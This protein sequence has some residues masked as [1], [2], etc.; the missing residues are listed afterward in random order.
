MEQTRDQTTQLSAEWVGGAVARR[1][2]CAWRRRLC[3]TQEVAGVYRLDEGAVRD[4]FF[5]CLQ[6]LEVLTGLEGG[7]QHRHLV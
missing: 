6:V 5:H 4:D 1:T 2:I 7:L 3:R